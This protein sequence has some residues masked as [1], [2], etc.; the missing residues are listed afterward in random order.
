MGIRP[1]SPL[2]SNRLY[3]PNGMACK[4]FPHRRPGRPIGGRAAA[5][6]TC[7][8]RRTASAATP[9]ARCGCTGCRARRGQPLSSGTRASPEPPLDLRRRSG[10]HVHVSTTRAACSCGGRCRRYYG[11]VPARR[12]SNSQRNHA[13]PGT[14]DYLAGNLQVRRRLPDALPEPGGRLRATDHFQRR[15][16]LSRV[17]PG[18]RSRRAPAYSSSRRPGALNPI[19]NARTGH[20]V[21]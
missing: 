7:G 9:A 2:S 17:R 16:P 12:Q 4:D 10:H 21:S 6:R 20:L 15:G 19:A 18:A 3:R 11:P 8:C 13:D 5:G 14:G 1:A